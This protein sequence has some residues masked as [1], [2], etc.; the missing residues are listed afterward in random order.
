MRPGLYCSSWL[1]LARDCRADAVPLNC[2]LGCCSAVNAGSVAHSIAAHASVT[3]HRTICQ[4]AVKLCASR[5]MLCTPVS[6]ATGSVEDIKQKR[7]INTLLMAV[8][9]ELVLNSTA[10]A[11]FQGQPPRTSACA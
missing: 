9:R 4:D 5:N 7:H 6:T 2:C 11:E 10:R 8:L 3:Q 1:S